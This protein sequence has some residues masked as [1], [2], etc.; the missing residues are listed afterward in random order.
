M[1]RYSS[2]L[3]L[4]LASARCQEAAKSLRGSGP[5]SGD[6]VT[7]ECRDWC[8]ERHCDFIGWPYSKPCAGCDFCKTAVRYNPDAAAKA[9][10][11]A[12]SKL[13]LPAKDFVVKTTTEDPDSST[14][15]DSSTATDVTS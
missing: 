15:E 2:L 7:D 12:S 9:F 11:E 6:A 5:E 3:S 4:F 13:V 1:S 14:T 10:V 8:S